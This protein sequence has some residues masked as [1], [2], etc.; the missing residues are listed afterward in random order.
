MTSINGDSFLNRW[1]LAIRP[2]TLP[3][4]V[5]P[6]IVGLAVAYSSGKVVSWL[7][8]VA[9]LLG[10][11]LLQIGSNLAND[12]FDFKKGADTPDRL[13]PTRVTQA[14][15]ISERQV[16]LGMVLTFLLATVVGVYLVAHSGMP[17]VYIGLAS[18]AAA[19]LYTGGPLP[20]GYKGLGEIFVFTFFGPVAVMG[21][22]FVLTGRPSYAGALAGVP[23][24]LLC[25]NVLVVNN[26]RDRE[27]DLRSNKRT[28]IALYGR[29]F[30]LNLYFA[31]YALSLFAILALVTVKSSAWIALPAAV[32]P[33][34][35]RL[36]TQ[37]SRSDGPALNPLLGETARFQLLF[38][39][40]QAVSMILAAR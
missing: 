36:F 10:A 27:Q 6:V 30:G 13:G 35:M 33:V 37:I 34:F 18:I 4:S 21:T 7:P 26:L 5:S 14:G 15:L 25:A 29:R 32:T 9:C 8:G 17:I 24:G 11:L 16:L 38:C 31:N 28:L 20:Y 12:Y 40:I 23:S 1:L 19:I 3:A 39:T 2:K 22:E